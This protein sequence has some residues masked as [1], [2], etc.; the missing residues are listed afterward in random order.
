MFSFK[1]HTAKEKEEIELKR[2][3]VEIVTE[4]AAQALHDCISS[5]VFK[6]YKGELKTANGAL[7]LLGIDIL[8]KVR[9]RDERLALY[10]SLFTRAE[11]LSLLLDSIDRDKS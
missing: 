7:M 3:E 11:V 6:K 9:N 1:T 8:G 5:D 10:D 2:K 4:E